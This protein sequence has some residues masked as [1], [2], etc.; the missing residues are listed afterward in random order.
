MDE[1]HWFTV[2]GRLIG[3]LT[4]ISL[5]VFCIPAIAGQP[6]LDLK[7]RWVYVQTNLLVDKNVK[8]VLALVERA[9]KA[10]YNGIVLTDS[11]FN[12][13]DS[14]PE[15]YVANVRQVRQA[16]RRLKLDCIACVCPMGYSNDL[17]SRDVNLAEGL[18]V[19]D[20][21]FVVRGGKLVPADDSCTLANGDFEKFKGNRFAGWGATT[22]S[23]SSTTT[24]SPAA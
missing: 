6:T 13:W 4:A 16:C 12:R 5:A 21:P 18:P 11:K 7:Y 14:L 20:A 10:G 17:L 22:T 15:R 1:E 19:R 3:L 9:S 23:P 2:G 24:R 8:D